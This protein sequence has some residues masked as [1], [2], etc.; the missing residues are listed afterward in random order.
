MTKQKVHLHL[1]NFKELKLDKNTSVIL[2]LRKN[3][4]ELDA[5]MEFV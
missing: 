2:K 3:L 5:S 1:N 4:N